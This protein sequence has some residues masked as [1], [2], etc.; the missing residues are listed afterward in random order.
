MTGVRTR[1]QPFKTLKQTVHLL[2]PSR[3]STAHLYERPR[4]VSAGATSHLRAAEQRVWSNYVS[5][6]NRWL[7][8]LSARVHVCSTKQCLQPIINYYQCVCATYR[9][10]LSPLLRQILDVTKLLYYCV[11]VIDETAWWSHHIDS[12]LDLRLLKIFYAV[13]GFGVVTQ[14]QRKW[15]RVDAPLLGH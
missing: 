4:I 2:H 5:T 3:E 8:P 9:K 13:N 7:H 1:L 12:W 11:F 10:W 6:L 14:L 15:C